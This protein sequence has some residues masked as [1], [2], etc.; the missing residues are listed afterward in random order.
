MED[1]LAFTDELLPL[2]EE[3]LPILDRGAHW[4]EKFK[5]D[6]YDF[7]DPQFARQNRQGKFA[8][9]AIPLTKGY[10]MIVSPRDYKKMTR[11]SDGSPKKWHA[12]IDLDRE[13]NVTKVYARRRGEK[14]LGEPNDV[15]AH[16]EIVSLHSAGIVDHRNGW[17]LDNRRCNLQQTSHSRNMSNCVRVRSVHH[18]LLPGVE[19]RG[20]RFGG[21]RAKRLSKVQVKVIR[22]KRTWITQEPAAAWYRNQL[23]RLHKRVDWASDPKS[24][25][26]PVFPPRMDSEPI[27]SRSR[28][29]SSATHME[30]IPY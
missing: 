29:V 6:L 21:I 1:A 19:R 2:S 9:R 14:S 5:E 12:K 24:V 3:A 17:G 30:D 15:Y 7:S 26:Y 10:F 18:G 28:K 4:S 23:K 11:Y 22:S 27:S 25:N 20:N 8:F 16:R 13:G